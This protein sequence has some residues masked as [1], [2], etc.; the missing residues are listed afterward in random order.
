MQADTPTARLLLGVHLRL[1]LPVKDGAPLAAKTPQYAGHRQLRLRCRLRAGVGR[2]AANRLLL[3]VE[4]CLRLPVKDG[5]PLA[6]KTRMMLHQRRRGATQRT[7]HR[8]LRRLRELRLDLG[9]VGSAVQAGAPAARLLL[10]VQ[11]CLR[12]AVEYRA[13]LP[14]NAVV[15]PLLLRKRRVLGRAARRCVPFVHA[16]PYTPAVVRPL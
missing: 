4:L 6:A 1:R 12:L 16:T 7:G 3:G 14:A 13:P 10:G 15:P 5:A 9:S 8:Q 11:L 2:A